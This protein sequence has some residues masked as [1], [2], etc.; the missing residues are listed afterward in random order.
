[1][2]LAVPVKIISIDGDE[3]EVEIGGVRQRIGI[4][5]TPEAKIGDYVLLHAG[6]AINIINESEAQETLKMFQEIAN[7][8]PDVQGGN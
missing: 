2:C 7:L 4:A 1:M 5:L 3:A 8:E 6:Y